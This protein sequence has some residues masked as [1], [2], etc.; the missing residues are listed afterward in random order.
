MTKKK[1][2]N[3]EIDNLID[4]LVED[5]LHSSDQEV[6][7][8]MSTETDD[9]KEYLDETKNLFEA[10]LLKGAQTKWEKLKGEYSQKRD[11]FV[12]EE[13]DLLLNA[14]DLSLFDALESNDGTTLAA[15]NSKGLSKE[16]K[17]KILSDLRQLEAEDHE[18]SSDDQDRD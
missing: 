5:I 7:D 3:E 1:S 13:S 10:A 15:R 18:E 12:K 9:V 11:V 17:L 8:E 6:R 14:N 16:D 4:Q 2:V